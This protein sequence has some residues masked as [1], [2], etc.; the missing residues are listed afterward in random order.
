MMEWFEWVGELIHRLTDYLINPSSR[1]CLIYFLPAALLAYTQQGQRFYQVSLKDLAQ[2]WLGR[3]ALQDY[4][5]I[6][7][8]TTLKM[9]AFSHLVILGVS[10]SR[11]VF[12]GLCSLNGSVDLG[13]SPFLV[14]SVYTVSLTLIDDFSVYLIHRLMHSSHLLWSIHSIH[15]SAEQLTPLTWLRIHPVEILLNTLRRAVI[16]GCVTGS[17][18]YLSGGAVSEMQLLSVNVFSLLFFVMGANLRHSHV[19][20]SYGD[21]LERIFI[22]PLQHQIH[23][24][25]DPRHLHHNFGSKFALWDLFFGTLIKSGEIERPLRFGKPLE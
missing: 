14:I 10:L 18:M 25:S 5:L 20:I 19:E 8:N 2:R 12:H 13:L 9:T 17:A 21:Q 3:S 24:S 15:H 22:S 11:Q 23:H 1:L 6:L 4:G 7:L 16:Y